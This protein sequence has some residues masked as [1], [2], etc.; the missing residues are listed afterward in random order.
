MICKMMHRE[1]KHNTHTRWNKIL[2]LGHSQSMPT[3]EREVKDLQLRG[4][5]LDIIS[6]DIIRPTITKQRKGKRHAGLRG[7]GHSRNN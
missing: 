3:V 1:D 5:D 6:R 4:P 2:P 7:T